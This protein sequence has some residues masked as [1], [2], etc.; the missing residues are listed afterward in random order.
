MDSHGSGN[1]SVCHPFRHGLPTRCQP[2]FTVLFLDCASGSR[3]RDLAARGR[4]FGPTGS[5]RMSHQR[6]VYV[7]DGDL[8]TRRSLTSLLALMG[9]EAWPFASG[10]EFLGM[11]DHLM[12]AGVLLPNGPPGARGGGDPG[13]PGLRGKAWAGKAT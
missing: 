12:P 3:S 7:V 4:V 5:G 11:I 9:G 10:A 2:G 8:G 6:T 13:R 1:F